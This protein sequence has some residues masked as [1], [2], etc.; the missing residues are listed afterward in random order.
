ML[1]LSAGDFRELAHV[2][3]GRLAKFLD[4]QR[5]QAMAHAITQEG[6]ILIRG[7]LAPALAAIT[8]ELL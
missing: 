1:L 5:Q 2:L 6:N 3:D 7:I 4:D 8:Q